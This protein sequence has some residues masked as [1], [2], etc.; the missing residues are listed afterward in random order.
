MA[1][2]QRRFGKEFFLKIAPILMVGVFCLFI[3]KPAW[4]QSQ[5]YKYKYFGFTALGNPVTQFLIDFSKEAKDL[6]KNQLDIKVYASGELPY[7]PSDVAS[8]TSKGLVELGNAEIS[9][10]AGEVPI[11]PLLSLP[12]LVSSKEESLKAGKI[13]ISHLDK[14]IQEKYNTKILWWYGWPPR[15]ILGKGEPPKFLADLKGKKIRF[16][17]PIGSEFLI[18]LGMTPV[19]IPPGEVAIALQRGTLDGTSGAYVFL[20]GTKWYELCNWG[21]E[22]DCGGVFNLTLINK[23]AY[24]KLPSDIKSVLNN[25]GDKYVNK[26][27]E[28]GYTLE[29]KSKE[30]FQKFGLKFVKPTAKD[31]EQAREKILPFWDEWTKSKGPTAVEILKEVRQALGK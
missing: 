29:D 17:G 26:C 8:I 2:R 13:F 23:N 9:Y 4:S 30:N 31:I 27:N 5:I 3:S 14:A 25:L 16:P 15:K 6:T 20:E 1:I 24:E 11:S 21:Y 22:I 18:R 7:Q 12:L 19:N 28:F 10:L